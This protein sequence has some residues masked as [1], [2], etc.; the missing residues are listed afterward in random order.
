MNFIRRSL[1]AA[2]G[3]L[4]AIAA[5]ANASTIH[6]IPMTSDEIE[7]FQYETEQMFEKTI[8]RLIALPD[9]QKTAESVLRP[10]SRLSNEIVERF[11]VLTFL[12]YSELPCCR[13]AEEALED[14]L[15]YLSESVVHNENLIHSFI[16]F[17]DRALVENGEIS[18]YDCHSLNCV[19]ESCE[20]VSGSLTSVDEKV[21]KRLTDLSSRHEMTP[22]RY[23]KGQAPEKVA[24][25]GSE[26]TV[27]SLNTCFVPG[28]YPYLF[29]GVLLPWKDRVSALADKILSVNAD[30]VCLQEVHA[31]DASNALYEELKKEYSHF[32]TAIGPRVLG[33][34]LESLGLPSGLFIASKYP[35]ENPQFTLFSLSGVQMNY[36]FFD[37]QIKCGNDPIGHIYTTHMQSLKYHQFDQI[38]A[39]QLSQ[40]LEKMEDD[41]KLTHR[42]VPFFLCGD[43]NIPLGSD[44]PGLELIN[45]Y[46]E[47]DYNRDQDAVNAENRTCTDYFTN[48]FFSPTKNF[49]EIEP[50]FQIIDYALLHR[51]LGSS[52]HEIK[53][54][55]VRMNDLHQPEMAISDHH[56]LLT[57]IKLK[58]ER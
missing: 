39:A 43:F 55:Q 16:T 32:Y 7:D 51:Y 28:R 20:N 49:G 47:D 23:L 5:V 1:V 11:T 50:Y 42:N 46:F 9:D 45:A 10:W 12:A 54:L 19:L 15:G 27:L 44:E 30:V 31:E 35:I 48:Y 40:I 3:F 57:T 8:D 2:T 36:G 24:S 14:L 38:R 17:A 21:L 53:T 34:S 4:C 18:P 33:F 22:Y 37:F 29:G 25:P 58:E 13:D 26:F 41:S 52:E 56:G 6:C